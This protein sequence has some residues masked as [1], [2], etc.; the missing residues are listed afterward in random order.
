MK[1][2]ISIPAELILAVK[3]AINYRWCFNFL[4]HR[5]LPLFGDG[6]FK[7]LVSCSNMLPPYTS[8]VYAAYIVSSKFQAALFVV[9]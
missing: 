4:N 8:V 5:Y 7:I 2:I 6:A 9:K 1:T 3:I